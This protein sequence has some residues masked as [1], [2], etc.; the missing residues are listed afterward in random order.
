MNAIK[1]FLSRLTSS[2]WLIHVEGKDGWTLVEVTD[3]FSS[4][5]AN[6]TALFFDVLESVFADFKEVSLSQKVDQWQWKVGDCKLF[7][8]RIQQSFS[9][10]VSLSSDFDSS[11]LPESDDR[12]FVLH[13]VHPFNRVLWQEIVRFGMFNLPNMAHSLD[14][15]PDGW[16]NKLLD[17]NRGIVSWFNLK[18][19]DA[20]FAKHG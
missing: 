16:Q 18:I 14:G 9:T 7:A 19:D 2:N 11:I 6:P 15:L 5:R 10:T 20:E 3:H 1:S 12:E 13:I 17:I 4:L 8:N